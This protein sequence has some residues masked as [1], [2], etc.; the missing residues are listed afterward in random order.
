LLPSSSVFQSA[1]ALA[2]NHKIPAQQQAVTLVAMLFEITFYIEKFIMKY[3]FN[4]ILLTLSFSSFSQVSAVDSI[5]TLKEIVRHENSISMPGIGYGGVP[6]RQ[7]YSS[8]FLISLVNPDELVQMINDTSASL[9]L[10][11][12]IGLV[13][14]NYSEL[15][16]IKKQLS[17]DTTILRSFEGC[18]IDRTTV[19]YAVNHIEEWNAVHPM[20]KL[21]HKMSIDKIYRAELFEALVHKKK[22]RRYN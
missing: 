15:S 8:A 21:L 6:S 3:L 19:S 17:S 2:G 14:N 18:I 10:Y 11:A 12:F 4:L 1:V 22:I 13:Y 16:S 5:E 20:K 7:W 9:R